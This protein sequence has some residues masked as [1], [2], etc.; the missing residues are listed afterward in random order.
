[1]KSNFG[2]QWRTSSV[3]NVFSKDT[4][5]TNQEQVEDKLKRRDYS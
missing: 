2:R 4:L 3:A 5:N 1:M